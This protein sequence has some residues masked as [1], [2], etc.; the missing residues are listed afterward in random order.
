MRLASDEAPGAAVVALTVADP[1]SVAP[2][3]ARYVAVVRVR[4][5]ADDGFVGTVR[6]TLPIGAGLSSP[7]AEW[8]WPWLCLRRLTP[9]AG[10]ACRRAEQVASGVPCGVMDP[11]AAA[12]GVTVM[13][14]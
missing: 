10:A 4:A 2:P 13:P 12:A 5:A 7:G 11:L 6:T 3:W 14:C 1:S 9:P 8:P